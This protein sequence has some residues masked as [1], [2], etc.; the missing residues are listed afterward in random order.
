M[1]MDF[2]MLHEARGRQHLS[3]VSI[4]ALLQQD[5]LSLYIAGTGRCSVGDDPCK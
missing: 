2:Q 5:D 4:G 1:E 3:S